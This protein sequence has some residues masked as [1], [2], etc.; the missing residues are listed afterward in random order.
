MPNGF[1]GYLCLISNQEAWEG[2]G[3]GKKAILL[4]QTGNQQQQCSGANA[5]VGSGVEQSVAECYQLHR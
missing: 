2:P 1:M 5:F 3:C 4:Q